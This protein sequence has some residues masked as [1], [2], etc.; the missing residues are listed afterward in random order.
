MWT[1]TRITPPSRYARPHALAPHPDLLT[2]G[3]GALATLALVFVVGERGMGLEAGAIFGSVVFLAVVAGFIYVPWV[4]VA[5][6]IPV[7]A[8]LPTLQIFVHPSA[9]A[10]KDLI[11]VAALAAAAI[12]VVQRR[13]ARKEVGL[14][15]AVMVLIGLIAT[16][17]LTNIGGNLSGESGYG[18]AWFHSVRLF[19]QPLSLLAAGLVLPQPRRTFAAA[20][21]SLVITA[22]SVAAYGVLQQVVGVDA[23][24]Q[25][26]YTYGREVREINGHLRSFGTLGESFGYASFLLLGLAIL[27]MWS[28][29][30]PLTYGTTALVVLGLGASYVRTAAVIAVALVGLRLARDGRRTYAALLVSASAIAAATVLIA[31]SQQAA[32]R[33]VQISPTTYLTL[34]GRTDLWR[35][36]IG[37]SPQEWLFGRGV[38]VTGTAAKRAARSLTGKTQLNLGRLDRTVVDSG[39]LATAADIGLIGLLLLLA[40]L[41]RLMRRCWMIGRWGDT[42]GYGAAGIGLVIVLDALSREAFTG[43]PSAYLGMLLIG[44]GAASS[45]SARES[46]PTPQV[47]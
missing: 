30:R 9:G 23:L 10:L 11:S 2:L 5:A 20:A 4:T 39:Y 22:A 31:A 13:A 12:V 33:A 26:G 8:I 40:L 24:V 16:L 35:A 27:L 32:T 38:G 45:R 7:Y 44:V 17:Y 1:P 18:A 43:F 25:M 15:A 34:N 42:R 28:R 29:R 36:Q 47:R 41:L 21:R 14:D 46:P 6:V 19:C 37:D 3:L